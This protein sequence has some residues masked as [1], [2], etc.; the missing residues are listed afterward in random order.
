[1]ATVLVA[2]DSL[3]YLRLAERILSA[4]GHRVLLAH[5]GHEALALARAGRPDLVL[6]DV[7]MP[8]GDGL[9]ALQSMKDDPALRDLPVYLL[10][11]AD[12]QERLDAA[13]AAGAAG[14]LIKP[15]APEELLAAV[16]RHTGA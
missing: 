13:L 4:A 14:V 7:L 15:F 1:M 10:T 9:S 8:D 6:C 11:G 12:D 2:D 5:S 16:C 3:L